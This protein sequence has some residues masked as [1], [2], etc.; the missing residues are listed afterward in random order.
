MYKLAKK[1]KKYETRNG[2]I[3][4]KLSNINKEE[5]ELRVKHKHLCHE[6]GQYIYKLTGK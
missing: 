5:L 2:K 4:N 1:K 3:P 6:N